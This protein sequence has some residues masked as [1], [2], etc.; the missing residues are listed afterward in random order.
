METP[1]RST[2]Q[3][4]A[5]AALAEAE[6]GAA[7]LAADTTL[8]AG[9][10][11]WIGA[12]V[13]AQIATSAIGITV[14]STAALLVLI[15]G[16]VLFG[17]V[18]L[19]QL[20][21]FRRANGTYLRGFASRA[22]FGTSTLASVAYGAAFAASVVAAFAGLWVVVG[23]CALA[24]GVAYAATGRRWLR[25]YQGDPAS[26]ARG[27]STLVLAALGALAVIA[28]VALLLAS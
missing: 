10:G 24:G 8:P 14:G 28:L 4:E 13:A 19:D 15:A 1:D 9:Y 17:V 20:R 3:R 6:A 21:R 2:G 25:Q 23:C 7:R 26:H 11:W 27:E 18:A 22:V 5:A 16:V 12:A